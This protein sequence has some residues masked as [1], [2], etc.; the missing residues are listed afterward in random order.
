MLTKK[1]KIKCFQCDSLNLELQSEQ[2][3]LANIH[4]WIKIFWQQNL[5][6]MG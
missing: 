3:I 6:Y 4:A 2:G 5:I 1:N